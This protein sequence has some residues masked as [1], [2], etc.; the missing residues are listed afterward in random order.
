MFI[1]FIL[2]VKWQIIP[3]VGCF[4]LGLLE[5]AA[6]CLADVEAMSFLDIIEE[7]QIFQI[8][9]AFCSILFFCF[10]LLRCS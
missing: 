10:I 8:S 1:S 7:L 6:T 4:C 3:W 5:T 9:W 2:I